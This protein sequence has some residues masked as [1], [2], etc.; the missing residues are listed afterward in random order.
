VQIS[1]QIL[2]PKVAKKLQA[3][4][5]QLVADLRSTDETGKVLNELLS[6][7]ERVAIT[8]RLGIAVFL[9]K[10]WSYDKIKE[11]LKV[12]SATIASIQDR[13][14][15]PGFTLAIEKIRVNVMADSLADKLTKIFSFI[16]TRE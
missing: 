6:D 12:S 16:R 8:K 13:M 5:I 9:D 3:V 10:G 2:H 15:S 14:G 4:F 11:T 1:K 7:T